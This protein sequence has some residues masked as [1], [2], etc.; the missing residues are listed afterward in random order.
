MPDDLLVSKKLEHVV[1]PNRRERV[2]CEILNLK[3]LALRRV[4]NLGE[5][6]VAPT[7]ALVRDGE[8]G[9]KRG[10]S[11]GARLYGLHASCGA[12]TNWLVGTVEQ[13]HEFGHVFLFYWCAA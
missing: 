4:P 5:H 13:R 7:V 6:I 1:V 10:N 2:G 11:R 9:F 3:Q 8:L 12:E